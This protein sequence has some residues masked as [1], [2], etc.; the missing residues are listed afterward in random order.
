[1]PRKLLI[2]PLEVDCAILCSNILTVGE[3]HKKHVYHINPV[4]CTFFFLP[5]FNYG[6]MFGKKER[7]RERERERVTTA[8]C[9]DVTGRLQIFTNWNPLFEKLVCGPEMGNIDGKYAKIRKVNCSHLGDFEQVSKLL[10]SDRI[11]DLVEEACPAGLH[12]L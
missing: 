1:M 6:D 8:F 10:G 4:S 3:A 7:E 5:W 12:Q 11:H 2:N 9:Y